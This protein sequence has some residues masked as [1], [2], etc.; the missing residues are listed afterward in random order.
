MV[1][2]HV[3]YLGRSGYFRDEDF[4][5][6]AYSEWARTLA[7]DE[8][9]RRWLRFRAER[10][11]ALAEE[12]ATV[13]RRLR[14]GAQ[15]TADLY[16]PSGAWLLGQDFKE[17]SGVLD[18]AKIMVYVRPFRRSPGR[19]PYETRLARDRIGGKTLV[20]GLASWPPTTPEDIRRQLE[21]A[22]GCPID[23]VSFY[24]YGWT[25]D[26]NLEAIRTLWSG[27]ER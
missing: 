25:P 24:C 4:L 13:V 21:L 17:L 26:E 1:E 12:L 19:I 5:E 15:V 20:L 22:R 16:P 8:L 7:E 9:V 18:G 23:G 3:R 11:R 14:P 2:W 27:G 10:I 6:A